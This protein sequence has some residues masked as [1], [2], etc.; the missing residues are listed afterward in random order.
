M[1]LGSG[2][3]LFPAS[4]RVKQLQMHVTQAEQGENVHA[5]EVVSSILVRRGGHAPR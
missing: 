4:A 3:A 5:K 1:L 2:D